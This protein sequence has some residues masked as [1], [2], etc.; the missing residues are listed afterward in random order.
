MNGGIFIHPLCNY[1]NEHQLI[2]QIQEYDAAC[3]PLCNEWLEINC[4][5]PNCEFCFNRPTTPLTSNQHEIALNL[6]QAYSKQ[7]L[8][9]PSEN[10][11]DA[12]DDLFEK[13]EYLIVINGK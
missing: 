13:I 2:I 3:C 1:E 10:D 7:G 11:Y 4:G 9:P 5:D 12:W 6:I 8:I